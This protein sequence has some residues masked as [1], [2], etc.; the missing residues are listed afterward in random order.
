MQYLPR[1]S[2]F[3]R[4]KKRFSFKK[5]GTLL[6]IAVFLILLFL[7][8]RYFSLFQALKGSD[9]PAVWR[10]QE[11]ER[12]QFLIAGRLNNR[13]TSCTL[14]SVPASQDAPIHILRI[15]PA[16]LLSGQADA[17]DSL[18]AL[19]AEQGIEAAIKALEKLFAGKMS[20]DH[21]VVYDVQKIKDIVSEMSGVTVTLP[22]EYIVSTEES[23]YIFKAGDNE[24]PSNQIIPLIA[25]DTECRDIGFWAEKSLLVE[26]FNQ[27]FT[28]KHI[29]YFVTNM[30]SIAEGYDSDMSPRQLAKLRD[31]LQALAWEDRNYSLL[32]G[33]WL[34][35]G[36]QQYWSCDQKLLEMKVSQ[37]V[38]N[39]PGYD[40]SLLVVD[41]FN[42]N[43]ITGFAA[44]TA[45]LLRGHLFNIGRVD[46]AELSEFTR[47]YYQKEYHLAA[48]EIS[49][50]LDV[51]AV[52]IEDSYID[53]DN[54]VAVILGQDLRGR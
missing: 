39:I 30:G 17:T 36:E 53:S 28:L 34:A 14:L 24:I 52:L 10:P 6:T 31:S 3:R 51:E 7:C 49:L 43:G 25:S 12:V 27:L 21:Y 37:I 33:S 2:R 16:T 48:V 8:V 20:L 46:N 29:S 50:I 35:S 13:I 23:D 22:E 19:Y 1:A 40:K 54:P 26:V 44:K 11:N 42:G 15:P 32:P 5:L 9:S 38:N 45:N 47:I 18:V 41:V 4:K